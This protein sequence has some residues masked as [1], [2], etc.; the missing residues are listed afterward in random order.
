MEKLL[1]GKKGVIMGVANHMSL[2]WAC[3]AACLEQGAQIAFSYLGDAQKKRLMEL[4]TD[5]PPDHT[6]YGACE[7]GSDESIEEFF[8]MVKAAWGDIDF[9][10]HSIAYTDRE[11][12]KGLFSSVSRESF[13]KT[14]DI[15]AYSLVAVTKKGA[16]LMPKGGSVITLSYYGAEKVVPG[17]NVMGVAKATLESCAKYLSYDYGSQNIRVNCISAGALKTLSSSAVAGIK[18]M[19]DT[20]AT[21]SP[22]KRSVEKAE[23]GKAAL[24]LASELSTGITGEVLH[25]DCGYNTLG[26]FAV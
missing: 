4:T 7:V 15:S 11:N 26:M 1:K 22:L 16:E 3:A 20:A 8:N 9:I 23:V 13:A 21:Q 14:L 5:I 10:I 24:F 17:Y 2:A 19:M 12:L 6:L 25:V 18:D